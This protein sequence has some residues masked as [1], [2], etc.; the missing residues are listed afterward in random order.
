MDGGI[1][2]N[3]HRKADQAGFVVVS[4][5]F[6]GNSTGTPGTVW[7]NEDPRIV[8][9]EDYDYTSQVIRRVKGIR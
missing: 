6:S 1:A 7:I 8:G 5:A 4:C 2:S 3:L 9:F